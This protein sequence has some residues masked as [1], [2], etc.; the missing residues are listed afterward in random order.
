MLYM[1]AQ[2]LYFSAITLQ[3]GRFYGAELK[4]SYYKSAVNNLANAEQSKQ[5]QLAFA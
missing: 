4:E 3:R 2:P 5:G 1:E